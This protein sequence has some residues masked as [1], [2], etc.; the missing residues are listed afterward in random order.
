[1]VCRFYSSSA[2]V[3]GPIGIFVAR[4]PQV[5]DEGGGGRLPEGMYLIGGLGTSSWEDTP[6]VERCDAPEGCIGV[7]CL[8]CG[9]LGYIYILA[10]HVAS[11]CVCFF[12]AAG[13]YLLDCA[14]PSAKAGATGFG[15]EWA[16]ANYVFG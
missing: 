13:Q 14:G 6:S 12:E 4:Q 3:S 15:G 9:L 2:P 10:L 8:V 7:H 5:V 1:M 16:F 11:V